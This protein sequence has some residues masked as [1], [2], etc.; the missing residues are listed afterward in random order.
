MTNPTTDEN[1]LILPTRFCPGMDY[2]A[3]IANHRGPVVINDSARFDKR[4]K[5]AHRCVIADTQGRLELTVPVQKPYGRTWADTRI[6]LHGRWWEVMT[7]ALESAYGRTPYFEFLADD[8][9]SIISNPERFTTVAA[10]NAD[11][12]R[13]IRRALGITTQVTHATLPPDT[14]CA[15][16]PPL[17]ATPYWQVRQARLGFIPHLS[18]LDAIFNL[19]RE[20]QSPIKQEG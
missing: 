6:S 12:D 2:Y 7:V 1:T 20:W 11:F 17:P 15:P 16:I 14:P 13:A 19:A 10:L 4:C 9:L 18:I 5:E 3:L 8:F